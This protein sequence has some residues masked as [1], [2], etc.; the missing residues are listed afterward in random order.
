MLGSV[1][2]PELSYS[3]PTIPLRPSGR[4]ALGGAMTVR[5]RGW[6]Q[7]MRFLLYKDGNSPLQVYESMNWNVLQDAA[8]AG[9]VSEFPISNVSPIHGGSYSCYYHSKS[10]PPVWSH[11]SNPVELVLAGSRREFG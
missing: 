10:D 4:V 6:H 7:N 5:C 2:R 11:P 1:S 3:K 8:P 9:D